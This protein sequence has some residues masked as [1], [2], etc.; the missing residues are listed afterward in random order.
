M[1]KSLFI[2]VFLAL[3]GCASHYFLDGKRYDNEASF[4]DA[5]ENNRQAAIQTVQALQAPL[6]NKRLVVAIPGE[7][8]IYDE[9][10][11]RH[12]TA[13]GHELMGLAVEQNRN[14]SKAN[15]KLIK[16]FFESV[17]K[18]GIYPSVEI[19]ETNSMVNSLEPSP[20]YDVMYYTEPAVASGQYFYVSTKHGKQVFAFDRSG[21]GLVE[22]AN[23]F[24]SAVQALAVR[25]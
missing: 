5:V 6:T 1:K 20:D 4:Q 12:K 19:R 2:L 21:A 9:N 25:D 13:T 24:I 16:I 8:A 15:A 18:R 22:K 14:L 3:A 7:Q 17:Q 11:R 10:S 23:N